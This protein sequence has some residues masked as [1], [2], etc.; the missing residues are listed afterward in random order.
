M[1]V[2]LRPTEKLKIVTSIVY[3]GT[4]HDILNGADGNGGGIG[5]GPGQHGLITNVTAPTRSIRMSICT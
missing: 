4:A 2:T 1:D 3:T 5:F